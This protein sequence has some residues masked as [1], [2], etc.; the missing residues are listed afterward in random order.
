ML[1]IFRVGTSQLAF[2]PFAVNTVHLSISGILALEFRFAEMYYHF[3][4]PFFRS[5]PYI[6]QYICMCC[7]IVNYQAVVLLLC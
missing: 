4:L 2:L 5:V 6:I 7:V 3:A 1:I